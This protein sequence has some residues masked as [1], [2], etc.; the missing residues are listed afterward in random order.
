MILPSFPEAAATRPPYCLSMNRL[1]TGV[2]RPE[3]QISPPH[4]HQPHAFD[5]SAEKLCMNIGALCITD[6]KVAMANAWQQLKSN[7]GRALQIAQRQLACSDAAEWLT[8]CQLK[9]R[10]LIELQQHSQCLS[11]INGL[12]HQLQEDKELCMSKGRSLQKLRRL[13]EALHIFSQL[14]DR[15]ATNKKSKKVY[16]L[17]LVRALQEDGRSAKLREGLNILQQIRQHASNNRGDTAGHDKEIELALARLLQQMGGTD[18]LQAALAIFTRLRALAAGGLPDTPCDDTTIEL[19]LGRHLQLIGGDKS[20]RQALTIFRQLRQRSK[21][22]DSQTP[23]CDPTF[24]VSLGRCLE[25]MGGHNNLLEALDIFTQL[26]RQAASG[27]PDTPCDNITIELALGRCLE[28][29]GGKANLKAAQVIFTRLRAQAAG[30]RPDTPCGNTT[31]ELTLG[32]HLQRIGG[33]KNLQAALTI[34]THLRHQAAGGWPDTPCDDKSIEL[35][36]CRHLQLMGGPANLQAA[37][38]I[39]TRLRSKAVDQNDIPGDEREIELAHASC[40][41]RI[42]RWQE[43]DALGLDRRPSAHYTI[44]L[45]HS[46]RYFGELIENAR[47]MSVRAPLLGLATLYACQAVEK[48]DYRDA[49][50]FSQLAHCCRA[51]THLPPSHLQRFGIEETKEEINSWVLL[52]FDKTLSLEPGRADDRTHSEQWRAQETVWLRAAEQ[53]A[54]SSAAT[55]PNL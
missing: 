34:F 40:L 28:R 38:A 45:C 49:S 2:L 37:L 24:G 3:T 30:G 9:T 29:L 19:T 36:L 16:G 48:S 17:A 51:C 10:A 46:I 5:R 33:E 18:N 32:R 39:S 43:Y 21:G 6:E 41:I 54:D 4:P 8:A 44:D 55:P 35:T 11:F 7:P 14:Y 52:F 27:Q 15:Y 50:S 26:R 53:M 1:H 13:P 47:D 25:T 42:G 22:G 23:Y 31:I 20:M 12:P